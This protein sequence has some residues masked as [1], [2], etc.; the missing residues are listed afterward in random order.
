MKQLMFEEDAQFWFETLRLFGHASYGG[1]DFG[2]VLAAAS[3]VKPGDYDSWHDAYRGLAD[4]LYAEAAEASPVTARDLLLRAST[5]Y[6]SSEFFLHGDPADPRIAAAYD[7][8]VECFR[9]AAVAE[10]V[11]IP[12]EGTVLRGYFYRAPGDGPKPLLLMHNGFDGSAEECHFMGAAGGAERD[13]H[14]LTFDGPGQPSAIRHDDLVFRPDWEHVVTPVLDFALG[15]DGVD[16]DR[17]ALLGVSLGGMLALRAAAF[18][19]RLAAVVAV[20]GVYD[21]GAAVVGALPWDRAEIVRRANAAED[22]EFDAVLAGG[23]EANPTLR[24]ACDHGRYVLGASTDREF[25]AKYLEYT[26]EGGVAE[27]IT[28]PTLVCEA[29]DDLFFGGDQETEPRRLYAHLTAPKT[30]LTFTAEEGADAH[31]HVGAQRLATGR[32]YDWLDRTL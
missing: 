10:P 11:E 27:Q 17:V 16:P 9:R 25:V 20:D 8:S 28:C 21:A 2:E 1:S 32:I 13:Y 12:Y 7:R 18:E 3:T 6:F 30:L 23:R 24:W 15:L 22:P 31:C 26:L 5:Y 4:R 19:H 29:A 14:V